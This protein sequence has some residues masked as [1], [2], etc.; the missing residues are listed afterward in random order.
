M[1]TDTKAQKILVLI[2]LLPVWLGACGVGSFIVGIVLTLAS[3][4]LNTPQVSLEI[5]LILGT[6]LGLSYGGFLAH[7]FL[8]N[9]KK[10]PR[11]N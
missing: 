9:P 1:K 7:A 4:F 6:I 11:H 2:A 5:I 3:V 10:K 8:A